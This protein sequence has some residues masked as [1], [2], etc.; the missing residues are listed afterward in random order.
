M[1]HFVETRGSV[2]FVH[3]ATYHV[4]RTSHDWHQSG[5]MNIKEKLPE[6]PDIQSGLLAFF[7]KRYCKAHR[8]E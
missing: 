7:G 8:H 5:Q 6:L 1:N 2:G 4:S 3:L